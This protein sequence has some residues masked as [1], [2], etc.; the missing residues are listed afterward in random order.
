MNLELAGAKDMSQID[1]TARL[2]IAIIGPPKGG[3]SRLAA[4]APKV[5]ARGETGLFVA[6]FDDRAESLAGI[7]DVYVKTYFDH[8]PNVPQAWSALQ[9][10]VGKLEYA[11]QQSKFSELP[12]TIVLD[13]LTYGARAAMRVV[14]NEKSIT[15][16]KQLTVGGLTT[17][18]ARGYEPYDAETSM[19]EGVICRLFGLNINVICVFHETMEEAQDSTD[20]KPKFTGKINVAPPRLRKLLPL[21][22]EVWRVI[23]DAMGKRKVQ[24]QPNYEFIGATTLRL[25]ASEEP[26]IMAMLA[27]HRSKAGIK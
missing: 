11:A 8:N 17:K 14:L 22:N 1:P 12:A 10:Y 13:S 21:F 4:T 24:C 19:L 6:D 26:D 7:K 27:K 9:I 16:V 18:I 25:D 20:E 5:G 3:K 2:K 15:G 23:P